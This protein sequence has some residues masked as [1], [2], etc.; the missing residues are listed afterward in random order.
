MDKQSRSSAWFVR[1]AG[2]AVLLLLACGFSTVRF[3]HALQLPATTARDGAL[4]TVNRYVDDPVP[5]VVLV[6]SSLTFRLSEE[7]FETPRLRNLALAGGSPITGLQIIANQRQLPK[8]ILVEANVLNRPPDTALVK[9]FSAIERSD[10]L[11]LRPV[12]TAIAAYETFAHAPPSHARIKAALDALLQ[13]PPDNFDNTVYLQRSLQANEEDP[14]S[15]TKLNIEALRG[16]IDA[17]EQRGAHVLLMELPHAAPVEASPYVR[18]THQMVHRA[19]PDQ[20]RWISI[21]VDRDQLRWNDGVHLDER[22]AV[23]VS[24]YLDEHVFSK[25]PDLAAASRP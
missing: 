7:Y 10:G 18:I 8:L 19:F 6:G 21:D 5:D 3:G 1:C 2:A 9:R 11:F 4:A 14:S 20:A 13:R 15:P 22:S 16:L 12:R 17:L 25:S 23:L 24:R